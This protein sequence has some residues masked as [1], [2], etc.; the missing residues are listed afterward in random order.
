MRTTEGTIKSL[1]EAIDKLEEIKKDFP[2]LSWYPVHHNSSG[3]WNGNIEV[4]E[5][6]KS[7]LWKLARDPVGIKHATNLGHRGDRIWAVARYDGL[8]DITVLS[9]YGIT[10]CDWEDR[11][12]KIMDIVKDLPEDLRLQV[13]HIMAQHRRKVKRNK[14]ERADL[15]RKEL[16][17]LEGG[18]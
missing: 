6:E 12:Q 5:G 17:E 3:I 9:I 7:I 14:E 15:L 10:Y 2:N 16:M 11:K 1:Q 18:N 4:L 13:Y 8:P